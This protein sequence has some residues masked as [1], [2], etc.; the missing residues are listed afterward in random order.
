M[1]NELIS[2]PHLQ[3]ALEAYGNA[4]AERYKDNLQ[5]SDRIATTNL[6]NS[7]RSIVTV[8][9]DTFEVSLSLENYYQYIEEGT[10][11]SHK[12]DP[13][14]P[15]KVPYAPILQWVKVKNLIMFP[16]DNGKLPTP[17]S[18]AWMV[19]KKIEKVGIKGKEDLQEA[20]DY[21]TQDWERVI[22]DA[23]TDDISD[24]FSRMF[25]F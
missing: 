22:E 4:L 16:D 8:G 21:T 18:F 15:Y 10:G 1:N 25:V 3:Q 19:K 6:F 14:S 20:I 17:E 24:M 9:K 23:L 11:L 12:P 7:V 2:F 13:R 5:G